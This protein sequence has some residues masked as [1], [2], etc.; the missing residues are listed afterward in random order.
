VPPKRAA[1][2]II[3]WVAVRPLRAAHLRAFSQRRIRG[4]PKDKVMTTFLTVQGDYSPKSPSG[5]YSTLGAF[6]DYRQ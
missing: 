4:L 5:E 3:Y 1:L 2:L 6:R